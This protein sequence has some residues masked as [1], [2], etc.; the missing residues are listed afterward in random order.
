MFHFRLQGIG[1]SWIVRVRISFQLSV[2][3]VLYE[4]KHSNGRNRDD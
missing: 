2:V 1:V 4:K 3:D